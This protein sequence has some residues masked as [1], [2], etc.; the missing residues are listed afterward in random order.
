MS[1]DCDVYDL[2]CQ[3]KD[4]VAEASETGLEWLVVKIAEGINWLLTASATFWTEIPAVDTTTNMVAPGTAERG[5][6]LSIITSWTL[7]IIALILT[8]GILWNALQMVLSRKPQPLIQIVRGVWNTA[9]FSA[10]SL[11]GT[12][13]VLKAGDEYSQFVL[14]IGMKEINT[15]N[16]GTATSEI[17][18][19][20]G[21][22]ILTFGMPI[23]LYLIML[24]I[25]LLGSI[26]Q[27]V[28][29]LF[30][31]G[32]IVILAGLLPLAAAGTIAGP[33]SQWKNKVLTWLLSL[34]CYK[35]MAATVYAT[36]FYMAGHR[37]NDFWTRM[38]G[39]AMIAASVVALPALMKFFN[40]TTGALSSGGGAASALAGAGSSIA[41]SRAFNKG[42][43]A[44]DH[45]AHMD[46][47]SKPPPPG[48]GSG[49]GGG[50]GGPP[51]PKPDPKGQPKSGGAKEGA[52]P[53][54]SNIGAA[55]S[56]GATPP[57]PSGAAPSAGGSGG[58]APGG[59]AGGAVTAGIKIG[60]EVGKQAGAQFDRA[61]KPT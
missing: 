37:G 43:A 1:E 52:Q 15:V 44:Q 54:A 28:L 40:W 3:T 26:A 32:A 39:L 11:T 22:S 18:G 20:V 55:E 6:P 34:C 27:I 50:D 56:G 35:P 17:L 14:D 61:S 33:T 10:V 5:Y 21:A 23:A 9:L 31:E 45:A 36:A 59:G 53:S 46:S 42:G 29:L 30:R 12:S 48:G 24:L 57:A 41:H 58:K 2:S 4:L 8:G 49:A 25:A 38:I 51:T 16:W 60:Q 7:P 47:G 13:L 19:L